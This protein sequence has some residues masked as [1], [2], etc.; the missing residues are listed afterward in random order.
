MTNAIAAYLEEDIKDK[1]RRHGI[2]VWLDAN[3]RYTEFV[4]SL[5]ARHQTGDFDFPA[6]GFRGSYLEMLLQ[7]ASYNNG[8]DPDRVLIHLP[9]HNSTSVRQTPLLELY[10]AGKSY[11]KALTT[12]IRDAASGKVAPDVIELFLK[13]PHLTLTLAENWLQQELE[14]PIGNFA[15]YLEALELPWILEGLLDP[16]SSLRAKLSTPD[17]VKTLAA[18]LHRRTGIDRNFLQFFLGRDPDCADDIERTLAAWLMCVE[19]VNDLTRSPHLPELQ[20]LRSLSKP[21]Q[22]TCVNLINRLRDRHPDRYVEFAMQVEAKLVKE[23]DAIAPEDLG[24][25]D[26]FQKED[27]AVLIAAVSALQNQ[28]WQLALR[29]G[30]ERVNAPSLWLQRE[31][32]RRDV[33]QLVLAA[34]QFGQAIAQQT[35]F[36]AR[37]VTLRDA[38]DCYIKSGY[39]V[40]L[41]HRHF[42]QTRLKL[43]DAGSP[44]FSEIVSASDALRDLYRHWADASARAFADLCDREGFLPEAELQQRQLFERYVMPR[45]NEGKRVALFLVDAFRYEMAVDLMEMLEKV[46]H[47]AQL[48]GIYAELP[49]I[50]AIGMNVLAPVSTN[51][52]IRLPDGKDFKKGLRMGEYTVKDPDTRVRAMGERS[53]DNVSQGKRS[54]RSL[55]LTQVTQ[56]GTD[57]LKRR[58]AGADL[59]VIHSREIDDAGE[60][61]VGTA[62][63]DIWLQQLAAALANLQKI[64]IDAFV[65]TADHGFMLLDRTVNE[66]AYSSATR[67]YV[68]LDEYRNESDTVTVSMRSLNY[69]G[70]EGYLL[71]RR[72]TALFKGKASGASFAHGGNTLQ[73]RVIPVLTLAVRS[74]SIKSSV[75]SLETYDL[76]VEPA[77]DV[78]GVSRLRV[79]VVTVP[80]AQG[81]LSFAAI[82]QVAIALRVPDNPDILVELRDAPGARLEGQQALVPVGEQWAELFF[83]LKGLRDCRSRVEVYHPSANVQLKAVSPSTYFN[84][85]GSQPKVISEVVGSKDQILD[86]WQANFDDPAIVKVF[87][88]LAKHGSIV[89]TELVQMLGSPRQARRF[90]SQFEEFACQVPFDVQV[91]TVASGKRYIKVG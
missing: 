52:R 58:C 71:F 47:N 38:L 53:I 22:D 23:F 18:H 85:A 76:Q 91:E 32:K 10:C 6:I 69:E 84:V 34:A 40:D 35:A 41:A 11:E 19:Y 57:T 51:G 67:R 1:L 21:L 60:A 75:T 25:I 82:N 83:A 37:A 62:S 54:S 46:G 65:L 12:L 27:R 9:N 70:Q 87:E 26:T 77:S 8:I 29:W 43:L 63:F 64:G 56:D 36:M 17:D 61:N 74:Q 66:V 49:T 81:I 20:P 86:N 33:W 79:R 13:T 72:D 31:P 78:L 7:L 4:D 5:I 90:A 59:V 24:K 55:Q 44:Q 2:I 89:E 14:R 15:A 30:Q 28:D 3:S 39:T 88:H 73:E 45:L 42:E 50:T 68:R 48:S 16:S 80:N